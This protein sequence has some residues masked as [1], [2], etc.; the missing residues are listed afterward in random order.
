MLKREILASP[1][2]QN[3]QGRF[4][5]SVEDSTMAATAPISDLIKQIKMGE[6]ILP[7]FQ[8]GYVWRSEQVKRDVVSLYRK[9]PTGHFLIWKT[10]NPQPARGQSP[11][12][13]NSFSRL[14]LDGQQRL[15]SIFTLFEGKPPAFYE[16]ELTC[17][18]FLYQS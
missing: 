4:E 8:R 18:H 3:Q 13:E 5:V 12:S 16:G 2:I 1:H 14:I 7:E 11:P 9:Y 17:P 10:Y 6:L 15:T